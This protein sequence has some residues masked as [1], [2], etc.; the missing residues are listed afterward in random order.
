[1]MVF[2]EWRANVFLN[3]FDKDNK[4]SL[5][6]CLLTPFFAKMKS[7]QNKSFLCF[8]TLNYGTG[9]SPPAVSSSASNR[10]IKNSKH[11]PEREGTRANVPGCRLCGLYK[12][13]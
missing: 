8:N 7:M 9:R 5:H 12:S 4:L 10:T 11:R 13:F 2:V 3:F 6:P 1:M